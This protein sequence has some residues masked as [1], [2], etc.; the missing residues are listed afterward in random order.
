[1]FPTSTILESLHLANTWVPDGMTFASRK[2]LKCIVA[3]TD[4]LLFQKSSEKKNKGLLGR[5]RDLGDTDRRKRSF[6]K[7][8]EVERLS[9]PGEFLKLRWSEMGFPAIWGHICV[10]LFTKLKC[11]LQEVCSYSMSWF[12]LFILLRV[13]GAQP[14]PQSLIPLQG[15]AKSYEY[16]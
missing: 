12:D 9:Q 7:W 2:P 1:M 11:G 13:L 5:I 3:G 10:F 8:R 16:F 6:V 15:S 4:L 14:L